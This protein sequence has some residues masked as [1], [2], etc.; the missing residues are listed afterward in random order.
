M[1]M[2]VSILGGKTPNITP[3]KEHGIGNW[4]EVEFVNAMKRGTDARWVIQGREEIRIQG[5]GT[6]LHVGLLPSCDCY[7]E[8]SGGWSHF[9]VSLAEYA[10][11]EMGRAGST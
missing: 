2:V 5:P 11:G 3:D 9:V 8:C 10:A 7:G 6:D 4:T 1:M